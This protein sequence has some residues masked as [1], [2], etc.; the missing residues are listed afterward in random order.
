[1]SSASAVNTAES[2]L[3]TS[4]KVSQ[5]LEICGMCTVRRGGVIVMV[6]RVE[7]TYNTASYFSILKQKYGCFSA[8]LAVYG[9]IR[10]GRCSARRAGLRKTPRALL[11]C[12]RGN[13]MITRVQRALRIKSQLSGRFQRVFVA[14]LIAPAYLVVNGSKK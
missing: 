7:A 13:E 8:V 11:A 3:E 9:R 5:N 14:Y 12:T 2:E 1:M 6:A 4:P 10:A